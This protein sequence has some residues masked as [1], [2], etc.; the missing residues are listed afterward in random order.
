MACG[1]GRPWRALRLLATRFKPSAVK[2][3][4]S[5]YGT[6]N[7]RS[8]ARL[9]TAARR[10]RRLTERDVGEERTKCEQTG[11]TWPKSR[12][13]L[14]K[15]GRRGSNTGRSGSGPSCMAA[16]SPRQCADGKCANGDESI[17]WV[18]ERRRCHRSGRTM[19]GSS[20]RSHGPGSGPTHRDHQSRLGTSS[21]CASM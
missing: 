11:K 9:A 20:T 5:C 16:W 1:V 10:S 3:S 13:G 15:K 8:C 2:G 21:A 6:P 12:I 7:A 4:E 18:P 19:S 17:V 14:L